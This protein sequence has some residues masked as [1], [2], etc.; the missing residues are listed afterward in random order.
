MM[1]RWALIVAGLVVAAP[2]AADVDFAK[3]LQHDH[4]AA[5][6]ATALSMLGT[7]DTPVYW[8]E[9]VA[10][11]ALFVSCTDIVDGEEFDHGVRIDFVDDDRWVP[12][13]FT[14]VP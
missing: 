3:Y 14:E 11:R 6:L 13:A 4:S 10:E 12:S 9:D 1:R 5:A 7:C 8:S 2:A